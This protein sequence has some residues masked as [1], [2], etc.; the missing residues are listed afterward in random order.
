[1]RCILV[2]SLAAAL[3]ILVASS[4]SPAQRTTSKVRESKPVTVNDARFV[5]VAEGEWISAENQRHVPIELQLRITNLN[6]T[7][8]IFHAF[9]NFKPTIKGEDGK[10]IEP[11]NGA[12][13]SIVTRPI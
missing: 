5:T 3:T 11:T 10:Q 4:S 13:H 7:G 2:L 12:K 8:R 1:M 6:T 9:Y